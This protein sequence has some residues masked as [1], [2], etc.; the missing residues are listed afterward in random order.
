VR[1]TLLC[2]VAATGIAAAG[3]QAQAAW[4]TELGFQGGFVRLKPAGTNRND[5]TDAFFAP[6]FDLGP[7]FPTPSTVFVIAPVSDKVALEPSLS[8]SVLSTGSTATIMQGGLRIDYAIASGLYAAGG[9]L[10][11]RVG[12]AVG[13]AAGFEL[14][15]QVAGGYRFHLAGP[16]GARVEANVQMWKGKSGVSPIDTYGLLFGISA[17][18]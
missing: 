10:L 18:L 3:A 9:G 6:G 2:L 13:N 7:A 1:K 15:L 8:A 5:H 11:G 17:R 16:V 4:H 12:G 14:G